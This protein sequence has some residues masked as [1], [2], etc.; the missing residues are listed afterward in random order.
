MADTPDLSV[1]VPVFDEEEN[2]LPLTRAIHAALD[3]TSLDWELLYIDDGSKDGSA[4]VLRDL[5]EGDGRVRFLRF[6]RNHGQTAAWDAGFR[7][8]RGSVVATMDADLQNDPAD[9]PRLLERLRDE[10]APADCVCGVRA[11][12]R[13]TLWRRV[14]SRVGNG[15]RNLL[16]GHRIRDAGCSLR[17]MRRELLERVD[18]YTGLH[19]FLPTLLHWEGARIAEMEVRHHPRAAG[20]S[21]YGAWNRGLRGLQDLMAVRWIR[22]RQ[23][24]YRVVEEGGKG[25]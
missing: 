10:T 15:L 25:K 14:Q 16:T 22:S 3:P 4:D 6:D 18:L 19:R 7:A 1:V 11:G 8:A 17:V 23:I 13:D 21:K 9:L 5:A 12:R 24:R 20:R 2:L